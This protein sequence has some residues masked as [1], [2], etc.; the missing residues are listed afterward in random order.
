MA[1]VTASSGNM[2][3][4]LGLADAEDLSL[5]AGLA[6]TI[7]EVIRKRG[8]KQVEAA[9]ITGISQ[10]ELSRLLRGKL[11]DFSSDRLLAA[12]RSLQT[13]VDIR[14]THQGQAVGD[15]HLEPLPA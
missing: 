3:A 14:F 1:K 6:L 5:K 13:A 2:F 11:R 10:P 7:G 4:D 8:L 12:I 9:E 15:L